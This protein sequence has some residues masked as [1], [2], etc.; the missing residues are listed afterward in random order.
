MQITATPIEHKQAISDLG[1]CARG[2][3]WLR[4]TDSMIDAWLTCQ[5]TDW[6][7]WLLLRL[8][9]EDAN[10]A[11]HIAD[12]S[13]QKHR[14]PAHKLQDD[15]ASNIARAAAD[16]YVAHTAVGDKLRELE[17]FHRAICACD[18]SSTAPLWRSYVRY[19]ATSVRERLSRN[20]GGGLLS[21]I[22]Q[23][24]AY[25][26]PEILALVKARL[27]YTELVRRLHARPQYNFQEVGE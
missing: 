14:N 2:R 3:E 11:F 9:Y 21:Y 18:S 5:R 1:A 7:A 20:L 6:I 4:S 10:L 13:I 12:I 16:A 26:R 19:T 23:S 22:I 8:Q 17:S 15:A 25:L 27:P 24:Y